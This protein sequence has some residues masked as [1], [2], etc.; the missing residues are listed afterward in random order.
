[1]LSAR[2][3]PAIPAIKHLQTY[4]LVLTATGIGRTLFYLIS[5][6][7]SHGNSKTRHKFI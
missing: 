6:S 5:F 4:A 1:M 7:L 3:Q 2:F